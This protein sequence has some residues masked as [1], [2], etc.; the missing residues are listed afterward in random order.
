[1]SKLFLILFASSIV[2]LGIVS[3]SKK[4]KSIDCHSG[5]VLSEAIQDELNEY[6]R[7]VQV[8]ASDPS[9]A[10]C[11]KFRSAVH[12]Y[13]DALESYEQCAIDA[14]QAA[15]YQQSLDEAR[16]GINNLNCQ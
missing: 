11:E 9:E 14:G 7:A 16:D 5:F 1:M 10:N 8:Y 15:G 6:A 2:I 4:E 12:V 3:C 13:I